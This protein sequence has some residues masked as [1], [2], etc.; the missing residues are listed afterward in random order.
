MGT[1]V[2]QEEGDAYA[3]P[4]PGSLQARLCMSKMM[5]QKGAWPGRMALVLSKCNLGERPIF[6]NRLPV[7]LKSG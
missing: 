5:E 6:G 7:L 4:L 3:L 1:R 2:I